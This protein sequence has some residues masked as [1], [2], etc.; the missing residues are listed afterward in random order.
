MSTMRSRLHTR[1]MWSTVHLSSRR[2]LEDSRYY[3]NLPTQARYIGNRTSD[4][5]DLPI[6]RTYLHVRY[7]CLLTKVLH[8]RYVLCCGLV[9]G[10]GDTFMDDASYERPGAMPRTPDRRQKRAGASFD[11]C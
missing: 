11:T 1:H 3:I 6:A 8:M 7:M 9:D 5:T 10:S 4:G 2:L